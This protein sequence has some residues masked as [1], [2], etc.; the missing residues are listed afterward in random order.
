MEMARVNAVQRRCCSRLTTSVAQFAFRLLFRE[1]R[2]KS[3]FP[4]AALKGLIVVY[5]GCAR[6]KGTPPIV[7][8]N[9]THQAGKRLARVQ[10][11][12]AGPFYASMEGI[13]HGML[14]TNN[15]SRPLMQYDLQAMSRVLPMVQRPRC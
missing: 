11:D 14:S 5:T 1:K 6:A 3:R 10:A 15:V 7:T 4:A 12:L 8:K 13:L 9:A 2:R